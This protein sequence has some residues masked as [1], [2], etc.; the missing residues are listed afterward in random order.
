MVKIRHVAAADREFWKS[1]DGHLSEQGFLQKVRDGQGYV[2]EE[3]G[4]PTGL[5]RYGLF[6]DSVPFCNLLF[7]RPDRQGR[8]H[9][10]LLMEYWENEM[11]EKGYDYVL[12]STQSDE[13][14]QHFYRKLGYRDCGVLLPDVPGHEQP[15]ELFLLKDLRAPGQR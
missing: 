8:G 7:V 10:R 3:D 6:W 12:V 15:A 1:L 14:A 2:S 9:G 13:A 5:L 4:C 11:R